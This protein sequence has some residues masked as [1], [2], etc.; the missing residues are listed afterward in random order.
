MHDYGIDGFRVDTAKN[1]VELLP[2]T[3]KPVPARRYM[4]GAQANP[5]KAP[6]DSLFWMTGEAWATAS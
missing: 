1:E 4:N 2:A 5:S 3:A 6:D